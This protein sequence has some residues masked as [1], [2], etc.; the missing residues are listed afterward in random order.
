[1]FNLEKILCYKMFKLSFFLKH[2]VSAHKIAEKDVFGR[3]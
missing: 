1:M 2:K 3:D